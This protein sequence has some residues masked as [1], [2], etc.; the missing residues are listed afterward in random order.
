MRVLLFASTGNEWL[1]K[2]L[3]CH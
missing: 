1:H 2:A 3:E